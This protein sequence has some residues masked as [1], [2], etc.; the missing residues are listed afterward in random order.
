M[1]DKHQKHPP[2][3][4]PEKRNYHPV[5]WSIYGTTC[6]NISGLVSRLKDQLSTYKI[7]YV[8]A[9]HSD[10]AQKTFFEIGKKQFYADD[11]LEWSPYDDR[12]LNWP[13]DAAFI[14]GNH[15][16]ASSQIVVI[17]PNKKDSLLRR[18]EQLDNIDLILLTD[19]STGIYDFLIPKIKEE[20][21]I[22]DISGTQSI[23]DYI[24]KK[25]EAS[26]PPLKAIILAGGKS[27]RMETDKAEIIY[28][29]DKSQ[30]EHLAALCQKE[31]LEVY[32]SRS[33]TDENDTYKG[34]PV[35]KDRITD[36]GPFGAI[37]SAFLHDP[38]AAYL[39]LACDLPLVTESTIS[40]LIAIRNS[41]KYATAYQLNT[42]RFPEPLMAIY[43]PKV[44]S[45]MMQLLTLGYACPRK[46]LI[47]SEIETVKLE[48]E[49]EAFNANT[50]QEKQTAIELLQKQKA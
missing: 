25:I 4:R 3:K 45:K 26:I 30:V 12:L 15:Y 17:D 41:T 9:D 33:H 20:T 19:N 49:I 21:I 32:V 44:Y 31:G 36:M 14:N 40:N 23:A 7:A 48:N 1:S 43:E 8:D 38:T 24:S 10:K 47:N 37:A 42:Q 39:V 18:V 46:V 13:I 16:P 34:L 35:I 22:L 2:L 50:P 6:S 5:E 11:P 27:K 29:N 28:Q